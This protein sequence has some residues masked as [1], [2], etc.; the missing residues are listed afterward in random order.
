MSVEAAE[1]ESTGPPNTSDRSTETGDPTVT[2]TVSNDA[3]T[4]GF[5]TWPDTPAPATP[6]NNPTTPNNTAA[7]RTLASWAFPLGNIRH[8]IPLDL[9]HQEPS[10]NRRPGRPGALAPPHWRERPVAGAQ[11]LRTWNANAARS[12]SPHSRLKA[13]SSRVLT[14]ATLAPGW[15]LA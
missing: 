15:L 10:R 7:R 5:S 3:T 12:A 1:Y 8:A 9:L 13:I 6:L 2:D 11:R 14:R 4:R